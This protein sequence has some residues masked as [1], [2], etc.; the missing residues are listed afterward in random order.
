MGRQDSLAKLIRQLKAH[1]IN[2]GYACIVDEG[3][4]FK[5]LKDAK[6]FAGRHKRDLVR[7]DGQVSGWLVKDPPDA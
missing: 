3:V 1:G 4:F 6:G 2:I 7:V 5:T